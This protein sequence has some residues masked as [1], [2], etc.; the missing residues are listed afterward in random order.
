[1]EKYTVFV[2]SPADVQKERNLIKQVIDEVNLTHGSSLGYELELWKYEDNA[3]PSA[4]RPQDLINT[5]AKPYQI[6][7][8]IMWKRFGT[9]TSTAGSGTEEEYNKAYAEWQKKNVYNIMFYFCKKKFAPESV[10]E[11]EQMTKVLKFKQQLNS[12]SFI[13][14]YNNTADFEEKIRK[15]LCLMMVQALKEK[16]NPIQHKA[17]PDDKVL[18]ILR[19]IWG[20]MTPELQ[21]FFIIPYN[22]NRMKGDPGIQTRD[23]F[24]AMVTNPTPEIDAV[25]KHIPKQALP[26]PITGSVINERYIE[27]EQPWLSHCIAASIE[28]LSN[29]L[30][31]GQQ[32]T[33][34]D[35]FIDIA[36]NGTG[37]SVAMLRK[38]NIDTKAIDEIL[39]KEHL[40]VL[41][42]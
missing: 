23:L 33:A 21:N 4:Q 40:E 18:H 20:R 9:P 14:D 10:E 38:H 8:G 11:T 19:N 36:R 35:V 5:V 17:E 22:E 12:Q 15:H 13:W 25:M 2:A 37:D 27:T 28:R 39:K 1:M 29:A 32:L 41:Q 16:N 31:K 26:E 42:A 3:Y 7:I 24:A 6:F 34:L 30:P